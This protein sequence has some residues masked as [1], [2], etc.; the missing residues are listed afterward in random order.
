[1]IP[2]FLMSPAPGSRLGGYNVMARLGAG[3]MGEVYRALDPRL[4]RHVAIK[5]LPPEFARDADRRARFE[6]E[7]RML[8]ALNHPNIAAIYGLEESAIRTVRCCGYTRAMASV[9]DVL[10]RQSQT[11]F[12]PPLDIMR[13]YVYAGDVEQA[14]HW[15]EI[16]FERRDADLPYINCVP[17]NDLI[18][19]HPRFR[20]VLAR[21][22]LSRT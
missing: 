18:R 10:A 16:G 21:M 15:L 4:D 22:N 2:A 3:G 12:I 17:S 1:M 5:V 6:R 19:D 14:L 9:G 20:N 11:A 13:F 7:A 8:A